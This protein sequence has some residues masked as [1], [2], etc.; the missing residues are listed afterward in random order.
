V[1]IADNGLADLIAA[2][3]VVAAAAA[4]RIGTTLAV[5]VVGTQ[6]EVAVADIVQSNVAVEAG[7]GEMPAEEQVMDMIVG[8]AINMRFAADVAVLKGAAEVV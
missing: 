1:R 4:N 8:A 5:E 3:A 7:V 2:A 6:R